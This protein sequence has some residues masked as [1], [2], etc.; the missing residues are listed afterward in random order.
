MARCTDARNEE[1][2]TPKATERESRAARR[3]FIWLVIAGTAAWAAIA[4]LL[5]IVTG[6][7][8]LS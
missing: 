3:E 4:A 8:G 2:R 7:F 1:V 5:L 6:G